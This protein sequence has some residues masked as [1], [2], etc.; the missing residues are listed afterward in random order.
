MLTSFAQ[1]CRTWRAA[2]QDGALW[3]ALDV[4]TYRLT[5]ALVS[6]FSSWCV[7][8]RGTS[9]VARVLMRRARCGG[10]EHLRLGGRDNAL[11]AC[12]LR[13]P[14][15]RTL[16]LDNLEAKSSAAIAALGSAFPSLRALHVLHSHKV[17]SSALTA[18]AT[19][20]PLLTELHLDDTL[21]LP[22]SALAT[23]PSFANLSSLSL[24]YCALSPGWS[25][26][27]C[28]SLT[29]LSLA[30]ALD[31]ED[32][33]MP[34]HLTTTLPASLCRL[35]VS[36]VRATPRELLAWLAEQPGRL[37]AAFGTVDDTVGGPFPVAASSTSPP[38]SQR[39]GRIFSDLN[40]RAAA[41]ESGPDACWLGGVLTH[42][43]WAYLSL[44][45]AEDGAPPPPPP[46]PFEPQL[47]ASSADLVASGVLL[48]SSP[49][50]EVVESAAGMLSSLAN[51]PSHVAA[52]LNSGGLLS[53]L[54]LMANP[55]SELVADLASEGV[56]N[57]TYQADRCAEGEKPEMSP[58]TLLLLSPHVL[59]SIVAAWRTG[60]PRMRNYAAL[61]LSDITR[62]TIHLAPEPESSAEQV[63]AVRALLNA[64]AIEIFVHLMG[65]PELNEQ[66]AG[67]RPL[68]IMSFLGRSG[69][70]P[71]F[72]GNHPQASINIAALVAAGAV[73]PLLALVGESHEDDIRAE[74]VGG[75]CPRYGYRVDASL[76]LL[77]RAIHFAPR[78]G[79]Q[80]LLRRR[81]WASAFAA[82][83]AAD[84]LAELADS[85]SE[86]LLRNGA[87][88]SAVT[89][90]CNLACV[91]GD[92]AAS[93][94]RSAAPAVLARL[95][96]NEAAN[97]APMRWV[98]TVALCGLEAHGV[99]PRTTAVA[100]LLKLLRSITPDGTW[101]ATDR[102]TLVTQVVLQLAWCTE[103]EATW[104]AACRV[105]AKLAMDEAAALLV[106]Q[107][108]GRQLLRRLMSSQQPSRALRLEVERAAAALS[109]VI[110]DNAPRAS[111]R[112]R[113][114]SSGGSQ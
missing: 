64:G 113:R 18:V 59:G 94:A 112:L 46:G 21:S 66:Y 68:S 14:A 56:R 99:A 27:S 40:M 7:A 95:A 72:F 105:L 24:R 30:G 17:S 101:L 74:A 88:E 11:Q 43:V 49:N 103:D 76:R 51:C 9:H 61:A 80:L 71:F 97:A 86:A 38:R 16:C 96:A 25:L 109:L 20:C 50:A 102:K 47:R 10:L 65:A 33:D 5:P 39:A 67:T 81:R 82:A 77:T 6:A 114:R 98:A 8:L 48:S 100:A 87:V 90:L 106:R 19:L 108:G 3:R 52:M 15:L 41:A 12:R 34:L 55:I 83:G 79:A 63:D 89:A 85:T 1:V 69:E 57:L 70:E 22:S 36:L 28:A 78:S 91:S 92:A 29:S 111:A 32:P 104:V 44:R 13:A 54:R 84:V 35:D 60:S 62:L 37:L 53:L 75:A 23:V 2:A 42:A 26:T 58:G 93:V 107:E 110:S 45:D 73:A 4:R 31:S